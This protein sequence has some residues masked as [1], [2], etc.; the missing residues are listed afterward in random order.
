MSLT[1]RLKLLMKKFLDEEEHSRFS[2]TPRTAP[3]REMQSYDFQSVLWDNI[4]YVNTEAGNILFGQ[5]N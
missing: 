5:L 4:F 2:S 1:I 3:R